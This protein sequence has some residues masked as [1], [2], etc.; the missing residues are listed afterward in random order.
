MVCVRDKKQTTQKL[1]DTE[2]KTIDL[3]VTRQLFMGFHHV[4][5]FKIVQMKYLVSYQ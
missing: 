2:I 1:E 3:Y 5:R 4:I